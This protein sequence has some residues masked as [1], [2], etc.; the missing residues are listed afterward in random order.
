VGSG[1]YAGNPAMG[2]LPGCG[3]RRRTVVFAAIIQT[4]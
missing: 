4:P 3:R 2:G 1:E